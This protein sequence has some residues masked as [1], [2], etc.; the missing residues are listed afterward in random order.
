MEAAN[1]GEWFGAQKWSKEESELMEKI[2]IALK[3]PRKG[4]AA[5]Q[6]GETKVDT[7][8]RILVI[9]AHPDDCDLTCGGTAFLW[10]RMGHRVKFLSV[11]NGDAGHQ[12]EGGGALA[13]RRFLE[14]QEA[15]RR[16]GIAE[17]EVLDNHDGELQPSVHVRNQVVRVI[18]EWQADVVCLPRPC[19]YHPDHRSTSIAVQDSAYMVMVPNVSFSIRIT[20]LLQFLSRYIRTR[21]TSLP[22]H[23]KHACP[24]AN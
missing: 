17:Y 6:W 19:D 21:K 16:I 15:A 9:G 13:R 5:D 20:F 11:T 14:T 12:A 4:E 7:P 2:E 24:L 1:N 8:L 10:A 3:K 22:S 18:R 23:R